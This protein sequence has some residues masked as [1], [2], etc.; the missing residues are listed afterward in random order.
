[1]KLVER[2]A[3]VLA[4]QMAQSEDLW[5]HFVH[6][7]KYVIEDIREPTIAM[8]GAGHNMRNDPATGMPTHCGTDEIYT[9]M[10]D[11]ALAE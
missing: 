6:I 2:V 1:M 5:G 9:A 3:R 10:I 8:M 7:A 11:A 4:A